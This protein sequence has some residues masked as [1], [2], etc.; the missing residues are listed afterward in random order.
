MNFSPTLTLP[1]PLVLYLL[2][3]CALFFFLWGG[4]VIHRPLFTMGSVNEPTKGKFISSLHR[5]TMIT[6][7][8]FNVGNVV[9]GRRSYEI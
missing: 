9:R 5:I 6:N 8:S 7:S 3:V 4:G 2:Y 1:L